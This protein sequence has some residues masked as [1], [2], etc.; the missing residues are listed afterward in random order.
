MRYCFMIP[1]MA[2]NFLSSVELL[3]NAVNLFAKRCISG[4]KADKKRCEELLEKSL[5]MVTALNPI[6][7]YDAAAKIAK[8]AYETGK[9]LREIILT[10]K[11]LPE[12]KL[13]QILDP[14]SMTEPKE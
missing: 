7:G 2:H 8:E 14:A 10:K 11:I 4:L 6:I 9:T 13:N 5:A 12:D 1:V 3:A